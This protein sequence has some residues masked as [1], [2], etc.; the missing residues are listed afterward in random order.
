MAETSIPVRAVRADRSVRSRRLTW[1]FLVLLVLAAVATVLVPLY[2]IRPFEV[3]T[4]GGV[5][6]S[7]VLRDIAP[8]GTVIALLAGLFL[9]FRLARG[10]RWG[11]LGLVVLVAA[12]A[13][14]V[15]MARFNLYEKMFAPLPET[16]FVDLGKADFVEPGDM[17]LAVEADG[18]AAAFPVRQ[19][20]YHHVVN[21]R[22]GDKAVVATY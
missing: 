11:W 20:S 22:V 19:L 7:Y 8:V 14:T 13:G 3:Q 21:A 6:L 4:P 12:L 1:L 16:A 15:W 10:A 18:S 17:V 9:A 5:A 2:L